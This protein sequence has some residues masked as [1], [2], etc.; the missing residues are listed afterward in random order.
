MVSGDTYGVTVSVRL[1]E[2]LVDLADRVEGLTCV[3]P[4]GMAVRF[5]LLLA[6][7]T[8]TVIYPW[9]YAKDRSIAR[10]EA[11]FRT[12]LSE[13]RDGLLSLS[14]SGRRTPDLLDLATDPDMFDAEWDAVA[15][16]EAMG[17]FGSVVYLAYASN[18]TADVVDQGFAEIDLR[19]G[20]TGAVDVRHWQAIP[21]AASADE[22]TRIPRPAVAFEAVPARFDARG[23]ISDDFGLSVRGMGGED[24]AGSRPQQRAGS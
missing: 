5:P 7:Q 17:T 15:E 16:V 13:V 4:T 3:K 22:R 6:P 24:A 10:H 9:R 19:D 1:S 2:E 18:A 12:P 23:D 14:T 21:A 8:R 20:R 11:R